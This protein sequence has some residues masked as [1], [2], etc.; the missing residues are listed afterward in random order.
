M[1]MIPAQFITL[2]PTK[3]GIALINSWQYHLLR[4][5][6]YEFSHTAMGLFVFKMPSRVR[7]PHT[8][9]T[10]HYSIRPYRPA[11]AA[12]WAAAAGCLWRPEQ[13]DGLD[14]NFVIS[15]HAHGYN[16]SFRYKNQRGQNFWAELFCHMQRADR[17]R[18]VLPEYEVFCDVLCP[19]FNKKFLKSRTFIVEIYDS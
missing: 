9:T 16:A 15:A 4:P 10:D 1:E 2:I 17:V 19:R 13:Y 11:W 8:R 14:Q 3:G 18:C 5:C 12:E 7:R 6:S